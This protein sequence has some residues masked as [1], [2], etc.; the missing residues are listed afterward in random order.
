MLVRSSIFVR[1]VIV[2]GLSG[3]A[4]A[5]C[6]KEAAAPKGQVIAKIGNDDITQQELENELRLAQIPA[7]RRDEATVKRVLSELVQ[8]KY[9]VQKA[10]TAKLDREPSTLLDVL[11]ARE[12]ILA[13]TYTQ[14]DAAAKATSIGKADIDKYILGHPLIFQNRQL[15]TVDKISIAMTPAT[16]TVVDATKNL[17]SLEDVEKKLK[18]MSVLYN[19]SMG[20]LSTGDIPEEFYNVLRQQKPDDVFFVP[21][22]P[23][24]TFF[25]VKG[26]E[27]TPMKPEDAQRIAR[28]ALLVEMMR[29]EMRKVADTAQA[30]ARYEGEYAKLMSAP[31]PAP[32]TQ[33]KK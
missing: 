16:Q 12:Q 33:Q 20:S 15:L 29:N 19:R 1:S 18:E 10:I 7:D 9:L 26:A 8:R 27:T 32:Q 24:G 5:G 21:T 31:A 14:R 11:R 17:K 28:Q 6:N 4:L 30:E 2:L 23:T 25:R 13:T 3:V 22:G